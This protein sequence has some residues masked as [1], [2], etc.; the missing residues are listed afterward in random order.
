MYARVATFEGGD[1]EAIRKAAKFIDESDGPPEDVPSTGIVVLGQGEKAMVIGFFETE[2]DMKTGDAALNRM[3]P[4][5]DAGPG[6]MGHRTG[7]EMYEVLTRRE[8]GD[9][10]T[11]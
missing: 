9:R 6:S 10:S 4:D 5:T 11:A 2:E 1:P 3:N 8:A 7:V